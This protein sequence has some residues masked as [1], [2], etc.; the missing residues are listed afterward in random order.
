MRGSLGVVNV[1]RLLLVR[2]YTAVKQV[3]APASLIHTGSTMRAGRFWVLLEELPTAAAIG[4]AEGAAGTAFIEVKLAFAPHFVAYTDALGTH[5]SIFL[6]QAVDRV[7]ALQLGVTASVP[8]AAAC[9]S[10]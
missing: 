7:R 1:H 4:T 9:W 6:Q 3:C 5:V 8:A 10:Q 2:M